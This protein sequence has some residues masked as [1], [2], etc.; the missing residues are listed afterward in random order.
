[1]FFD[2]V[3]NNLEGMKYIPEGEHDF[4]IDDMVPHLF[5]QCRDTCSWQDP[6]QLAPPNRVL[7]GI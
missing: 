2:G 3:F 7:T 5:Y 6:L 1:M 4:I